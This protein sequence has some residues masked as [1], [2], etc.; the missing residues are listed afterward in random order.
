MY[1]ASIVVVDRSFCGSYLCSSR[2]ALKVWLLMICMELMYAL[3]MLPNDDD[4][5][6]S[7]LFPYK[8]V[9]RWF[10]GNNATFIESGLTTLLSW[11]GKLTGI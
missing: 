2:R 4:D 5:I 11:Q 7:L 1:F 8:S 9:L 10:L 6:C 3:C